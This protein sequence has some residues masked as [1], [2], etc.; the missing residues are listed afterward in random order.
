MRTPGQRPL[1][2]QGRQ[3][4]CVTDVRSGHNLFMAAALLLP[5]RASSAAQVLPQRHPRQVAQPRPC[6]PTPPLPGAFAPGHS[7]AGPHVATANL[8]PSVLQSYFSSVPAAG[9]VH[10]S[11]AA[12]RLT[13]SHAMGS[14]SSG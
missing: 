1:Q 8:G 5:H 12:T 10:V 4:P 14:F 11:T 9:L 6:R 13:S 3:G 7:C 2:R